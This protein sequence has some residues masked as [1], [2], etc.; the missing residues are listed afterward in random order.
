MLD[1]QQLFSEKEH[2]VFFS[3][4]IGPANILAIGNLTKYVSS[5]IMGCFQYIL[6]IHDMLFLAI[7]PNRGN[8]FNSS[9]TK[10][11][12]GSLLPVTT[13]V[14]FPAS[15]YSWHVEMHSEKECVVSKSNTCKIVF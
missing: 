9:R 8:I 13:V 15:S 2:R 11:G 10:N 3:R 7:T 4:A 12:Q 14:P 6:N 1:A 5:Q